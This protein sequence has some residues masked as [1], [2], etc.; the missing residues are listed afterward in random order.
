MTVK[1]RVKTKH[2]KELLKEFV[3]FSFRVNHPKT[4]LRLFV[5]GVGFLIIGTGIERGSLAMWMCLVIGILL[6]IFAFARHHIGVMQLK[7][8]D[9]IYQNDWEV[10]TSFLDGEIRIKNSG[11][12]KGFSKSYKEVAALYMDENNYYI[13]IEGDNL[14]PLPRKCF[15]EGKQEEFENFIKKE[16]GAKDDVCPISHEKQICNHKGKY[17]SKRSRTRFE[18]RR[19][20]KRELLQ[21]R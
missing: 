2:T 4:T 19:K 21:G 5:I 17:E 11:E 8:N 1:Y 12:T 18:I 20:E 14:Y 3:K 15:V 9:E 10:D 16:N 7:G 13:G 6:C